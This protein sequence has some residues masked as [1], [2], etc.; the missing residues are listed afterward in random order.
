MAITDKRCHC[1]PV[2][3]DT[4]LAASLVAMFSLS[5][6]VTSHLMLCDLKQTV[7][8]AALSP[9]GDLVFQT[10]AMRRLLKILAMTRV[11]RGAPKALALF[12]HA[13]RAK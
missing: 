12:P 3:T 10:Y 6:A 2:S 13:V 9:R 8:A 4:L 7:E 11:Q 5:T 1:D